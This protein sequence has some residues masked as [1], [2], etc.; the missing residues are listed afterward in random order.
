MTL[1]G[2]MAERISD[3]TAHLKCGVNLK[4]AVVLQ[5]SG[6][7]LWTKQSIMKG[8]T[9][10]CQIRALLALSHA[11][12]PVFMLQANVMALCVPPYTAPRHRPSPLGHSH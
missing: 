2:V 1:A 7:I 3:T 11:S 10:I 6:R 9:C 5:P 12:T 4:T 8:R